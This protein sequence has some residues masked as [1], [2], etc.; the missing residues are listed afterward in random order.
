MQRY[1]F[2]FNHR[3]W[4]PPWGVI[5]HWYCWYCQ[6]S[7]NETIQRNDRSTKEFPNNCINF[8]GISLNGPTYTSVLSCREDARELGIDTTWHPGSDRE[9]GNLCPERALLRALILPIFYMT[10][11]T[12]PVVAVDCS[13]IFIFPPKLNLIP[14]RVSLILR[15]LPTS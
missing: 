4:Q 8:G 3:D 11:N 1:P 12:S 10:D 13:K 2:Y 6:H 7:L 15:C 5:L 14:G 9:R